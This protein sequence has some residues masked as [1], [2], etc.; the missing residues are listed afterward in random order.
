MLNMDWVPPYSKSWLF[1]SDTALG[2]ANQASGRS[3]K[4]NT[5]CLSPGSRMIA[6]A[7]VKPRSF[8][9]WTNEEN[10]VELTV[11]S[12]LVYSQAAMQDGKDVHGQVQ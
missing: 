2:M 6:P 7:G 9:P 3:L 1:A 8:L 4:T 12:A 11:R 5:K 10:P